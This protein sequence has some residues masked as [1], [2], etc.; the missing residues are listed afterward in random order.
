M[1]KK[2][3]HTALIALGAFMIVAAVQRHVMALPLVGAYLPK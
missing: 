2:D 3:L 1:D